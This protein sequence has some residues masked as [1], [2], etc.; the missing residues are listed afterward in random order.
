MNNDL[1]LVALDAE[2]I[3][4]AKETNGKRKQITHALV[5]GKYGVMFG[6]EKQC[7]KYYSVWKDIF[8]ELFGQC[9]ETDKYHLTTY[10]CSGNVVMDLL[11]EADRRKPK[12]NFIDEVTEGE[13]KGFWSRLFGR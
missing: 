3:A 13:K 12:I 2:Q 1:V 6:T 5:V 7:M 11:E 4:E 9:Y 10:N 8:K